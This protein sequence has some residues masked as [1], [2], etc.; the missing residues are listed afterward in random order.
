VTVGADHVVVLGGGFTGTL[1]AIN[2][3]RHAGPRVTLVERRAEAARGGAYDTDQP[4][5]LLNVRAANM[6]AFPDDPDH[7]ARWLA[8]HG[9]PASSFASRQRYGAYLAELLAQTRPRDRFHVIRDE[10]VDV[11]PRP[12]SVQVTLKSGATI[13]ADIAALALGN[14]PPHVPLGIDA[15]IVGAECYRADPWTGDI[16]G[17]LTDDDAVLLLG[18]GLTA[19]DAV[20]SLA[21]AGFRGRIVALSRRGLLPRVHGDGHVPPGARTERPTGRLSALLRDVR[22]RAAAAGWR[23]AIDELRP[24][25]QALWQ[26]ASSDERARFLRHLRP[27]WDVH[28]HRLA[29]A[30]AARVAALREAGRLEIAAGRPLGFR[31][32]TGGATLTWRP[33]GSQSLAET[34]VRRIVN[35]TGPGGDLGRTTEP[36][37]RR[38]TEAGIIRPDALRLGVDVTPQA[39]VIGRSGRANPRLLA[40]GPMTRGVFWE[41]TAVPDIRRQVWDTARRLSHAH[42]VA[43][44]L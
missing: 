21:D 44:G 2:L 27:W 19:V 29:P 3:L 18:T 40:L 5:H 39:Q 4:S 25:T 12:D 17:G 35:C 7:F 8:S 31:A 30:V 36:L 23:A 41:I 16:A 14:L 32:D 43:E 38:L 13:F 34:K 6:S 15:G 20:L 9:E 33:R 22:R 28:R 37:L 10:A 1:L 11:A 42:W 26:A 24:W